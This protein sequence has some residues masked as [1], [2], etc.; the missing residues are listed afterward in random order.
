M[1]AHPICGAGTAGP[2]GPVGPSNNSATDPADLLCE[3]RMNGTA[4]DSTPDI[5]VEN[6]SGTGPTSR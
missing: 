2:Q 5:S 3:L 6:A 4:I 1:L